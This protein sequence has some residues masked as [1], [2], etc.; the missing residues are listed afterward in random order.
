MHPEIF[1]KGS[2]IYIVAES[3]AR[4]KNEIVII[5]SYDNGKNWSE[6]HFININE[7]PVSDF[8]YSIKRLNV[9]FTDESSDIDGYIASWNW[10]FGDGNTSEE[11]N[12]D[13]IY[14]ESGSK[15]VKLTTKDN[16]NNSA[17]IT[18]IITVSNITP[19][20]DFSY[21]PLNP[22]AG[23]NIVFNSTSIASGSHSIENYSWNFGDGSN[24][25]YGKKVTYN[26]LNNGTYI[27]NHTIRDN[28]DINYFVEKTIHIGLS[29]D[30]TYEPQIPLVGETVQ[31]NDTSSTS[32]GD[33]IKEWLWDFGDGASASSQNTT[34]TYLSPGF[35]NVELSITDN[36]ETTT[37]IVKTIQVK[38]ISLTPRYPEVYIT[39]TRVFCMFTGSKNIFI[40]NSTDNGANWGR[41]KR[42]NDRIYSVVEDYRYA[43]M[44]DMK[45]VIWTDNRNENN[46]IYFYL[47][48]TPKADVRIVDFNFTTDR[49]FLPT[50]NWIEVTLN[51]QGDGYDTELR[52]AVSYDCDGV[53]SYTKYPLFI[54]FI[55]ADETITRRSPLFKF[56]RPEF[57][58]AFIEFA[59][60]ESM[61]VQILP[62]GESLTKDVS[63][64]EIF[65]IVWRL[66]G[67]FERL[68]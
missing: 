47:G 23:Q 46:D 11:Q 40:I 20:T 32:Y 53:V 67:L 50:K 58:N 4:G 54:D 64:R 42:L 49:P 28:F 5:N 10:T 56:R 26:Y 66:E 2:N 9:S 36:N 38:H 48:Y 17:S 39:D 7:T 43:D 59:G 31:F 8:S 52:L 55:D 3:D 16:Y 34:H 63:Y 13:H 35:Y 24:L 29:A 60:I 14:A 37:S 6:P 51:N 30:F 68:K 25:V 62:D 57:L 41:L 15:T 22:K 45:H 61:T 18:K 12:P 44:A 65:Q 1:V 33:I 27:V 19:V 21:D